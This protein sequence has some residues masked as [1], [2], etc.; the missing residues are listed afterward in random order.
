M[1]FKTF[2]VHMIAFK[3]FFLKYWLFFKLHT[4]THYYYFYLGD[5]VRV[6]RCTPQ[7]K[8]L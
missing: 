4:V 8:G 1:Y 7:L 2:S 3:I 5:R 6:M